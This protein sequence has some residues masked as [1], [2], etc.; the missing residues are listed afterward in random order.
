MDIFVGNIA[1][2]SSE[3]DLRTAFAQYGEVSAVKIVKDRETGRSRGFAFVTMPNDNE[4]QK[5]IDSLNNA[6]LQGRSIRVN[7]SKPRE[8]RPSRREFSHR[9]A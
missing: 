5:A 4:A 6:E 9:D 1:F 8:D 7:P 3:E 2:T